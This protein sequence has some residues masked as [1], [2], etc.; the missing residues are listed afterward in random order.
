MH[1]FLL[2]L[3]LI[4]FISY[5]VKSFDL[6]LDADGN[7]LYEQSF[8]AETASVTVENTY[9][10]KDVDL[11]WQ[12]PQSDEVVKMF[13]IASQESAQLNTYTGHKFFVKEVGSGT[14]LPDKIDVTSSVK[15]YYVG[16]KGK[17]HKLQKK[18]TPDLGLT[19]GGNKKVLGSPVT[20]I[21]TKSTAMAAKFQCHCTAVDYYYDDGGD[22]VFQGS[23][24][25]GKETTI[26]TYQGH[27]FFFTQKNKKKN[28]LARYLMVV[29]KV[30]FLQFYISF[31]VTYSLSPKNTPF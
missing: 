12:D 9:T 10:D 22:G 15:V 2:I 23:L 30:T 28:V 17:G 1:V 11:Y 24:T 13:S 19:K 14:K 3:S 18:V 31:N 27:T 26:N 8:V 5:G 16:P 25:L 20:I 29:D 6:E 4:V 7:A 21:G